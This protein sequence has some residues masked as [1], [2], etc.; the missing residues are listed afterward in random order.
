M[1]YLQQAGFMHTASVFAPES[2]IQ[3]YISSRGGGGVG[4]GNKFVDSFLDLL[5][6][7]PDNKLYQVIQ[8]APEGSCAMSVLLEHIM[9]TSMLRQET[10]NADS[11]TVATELATFDRKMEM[12]NERYR[13]MASESA[14]MPM[15]TLEEKLAK[16]QKEAD[17]RVKVEVEEAVAR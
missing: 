1:D 11:Q 5:H 2:G 4:G 6:L 10:R 14:M 7:H 17:E 12:I 9:R 13:G 3:Q 8:K 16:F 15:K